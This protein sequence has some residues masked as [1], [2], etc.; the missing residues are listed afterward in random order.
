[1][2]SI[3]QGWHLMRFVRL[4][5]GLVILI[6]SITA[7]DIMFSFLGGVIVFTALANVGCCGTSCSIYNQP[8]KKNLIEDTKFEEVR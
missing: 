2:K 7:K 1:M 3:T 4:G 8:T 5:M 6:Q